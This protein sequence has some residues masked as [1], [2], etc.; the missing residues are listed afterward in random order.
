M[1]IVVANGQAGDVSGKAMG[2]FLQ[3]LNQHGLCLIDTLIYSES[4]CQ[5]NLNLGLGMVTQLLKSL[6][7]KYENL[8]LD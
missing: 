3:I 4:F 8:S 6:P 1:F 7:C 5:K 2:R